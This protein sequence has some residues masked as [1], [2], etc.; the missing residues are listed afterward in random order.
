[1]A[2][3]EGFAGSQGAIGDAGS[4][5]PP[6]APRGLSALGIGLV[7]DDGAAAF[8]G[9]AKRTFG[10]FMDAPWMPKPIVLGPRLRRWSLDELRA[11]VASMPRQTG[12][13][14]P[15]SLVRAKI[16]RMKSTGVS[17]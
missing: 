5:L 7:D 13:A 2:E 6:V 16:E 3:F 8:F 17:A 11:A 1:M 4:V 12:R 14:Q 9:V 10:T 15:E